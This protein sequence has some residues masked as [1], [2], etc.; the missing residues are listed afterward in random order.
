[1]IIGHK[2]QIEKIKTLISRKKLPQALLFTGPESV[3]KKKIAFWLLKTLNCEK[4][5]LSPC[6][7][8]LS[9]K[10]I[11]EGVSADVFFISPE[12]KE[13]QLGQI[14]EV[15][16]KISFKSTRGRFKGVIIDNAHL[17]NLQ[18]QNA[19]LK[20]LEEPPE[21]TVIVLVTEYPDVIL[22]TVLS[23]V[24]K[25][26]FSFVSKKEIESILNNKKVAALSFGCPGIAINYLRYPEKKREMEEIEK[27]ARK[28][29]KEDV[30]SRFALI[31][32]A[33]EKKNTET[34][35]FCWLKTVREE[36]FLQIE[37]RK[38]TEKERDAIKKIEE[39]IFLNQKT[40]IN[41][42]LIMEE[43]AVQV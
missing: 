33:V 32:E 3:G 5:D 28:M 9:C 12:K 37:K 25:I 40:N 8:C 21:N 30:V 31:K 10:E 34:F 29:L 17:M 42:Q 6:E 16:R 4:G 20:T 23:R 22:S 1:M 19:L 27:K 13:I 26:N 24:F 18:A 2:E 43:V 14:E 38:K 15:I 41:I 36:M 35:L 11:E 7:K 39:A